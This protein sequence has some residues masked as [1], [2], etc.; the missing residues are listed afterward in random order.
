MRSRPR[1]ASIDPRLFSPR[2][3]PN[4]ARASFKPGLVLERSP[5]GLGRKVAGDASVRDGKR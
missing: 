2:G 3:G 4:R 5:A 1:A